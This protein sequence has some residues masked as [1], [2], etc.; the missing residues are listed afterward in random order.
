MIR[1]IIDSTALKIFH[2]IRKSDGLSQLEL[3]LPLAGEVDI[4]DL[5]S[6]VADLELLVG[7]DVVILPRLVSLSHNP[8][9]RKVVQVHLVPIVVL[10]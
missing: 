7:P 10:H 6:I 3:C 4:N 5:V 1:N 8:P 9:D 2:L